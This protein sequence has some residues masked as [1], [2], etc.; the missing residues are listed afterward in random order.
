MVELEPGMKLNVG[1]M[2]SNDIPRGSLICLSILCK[3]DGTFELLVEDDSTGQLKQFFVFES[4]ENCFR[5]LQDRY[6]P[7]ETFTP[8]G[9][10]FGMVEL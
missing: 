2:C 6:H 1:W 8:A 9:P 3:D 4:Y 10:E 7:M 5:Y